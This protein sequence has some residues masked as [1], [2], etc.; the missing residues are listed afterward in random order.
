MSELLDRGFKDE[1][2]LWRSEKNTF[3]FVHFSPNVDRVLKSESINISGGGLLGVVYVTPLRNDGR[4]HNLGQYI[5]DTELPQ[6]IK[7][8]EVKCLVFEMSENQYLDSLENGKLN[9]I[10]ES[11]FFIADILNE[12]MRKLQDSVS[13]TMGDL[14]ATSGKEDFFG[15]MHQFLSEYPALKHFYFETFNE[16]LYTR[17]DAPDALD[18]LKKGE[19]LAKHVKD[20][21]FSSIP[22][23]KTSFSTTHFKT[24]TFLHLENLSQ[25][26][27]LFISFDSA[28][29]VNFM[30]ARLSFYLKELVECPEAVCGR[31]LLKSSS[32]DGRR[33]LEQWG[34]DSVRNNLKGVALYQYDTIPKGEMGIAPVSDVAVY[35][36]TYADGKVSINNELQIQIDSTLISSPQSVLRV[37]A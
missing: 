8:R 5:F 29:F 34:A 24:D 28:D 33:K 19:V 18:S 16:Y 22:K 1:I 2:D 10:F 27:S 12:S 13:Q 4:V 25:S 26:K 20:Y 14:L 6:S 35:G 11:R 23:L 15:K 3:R 21:L 30:Y 37:K 7:T 31:L 36:A 17:Q 32:E 9:Y